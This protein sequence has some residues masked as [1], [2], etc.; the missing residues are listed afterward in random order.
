MLGYLR[1]PKE[2]LLATQLKHL[3]RV[4][5]SSR[6]RYR[7]IQ[8]G[9]R[10]KKQGDRWLPTKIGKSTLAY[11]PAALT[12]DRVSAEAPPPSIYLL[13]VFDKCVFV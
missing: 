3:L 12:T 13:P 5:P 1:V 8:P 4:L 2:A 10:A 11:S 6:A 9:S 7:S